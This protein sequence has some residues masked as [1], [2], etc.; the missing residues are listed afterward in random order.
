MNG[1]LKDL[2]NKGIG[3]RMFGKEDKSRNTNQV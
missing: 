3:G 1:C 2:M